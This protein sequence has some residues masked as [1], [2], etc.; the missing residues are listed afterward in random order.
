MPKKGV[1]VP[2]ALLDAVRYRIERKTKTTK[3]A[4]L[5]PSQNKFISQVSH[6]SG[7][8]ILKWLQ[9]GRLHFA[10][11]VLWHSPLPWKM[12]LWRS[13]GEENLQDV[14]GKISQ[15]NISAVCSLYRHGSCH[16]PLFPTPLP[17][18]SGCHHMSPVISG[19]KS[20]LMHGEIGI[21][22]RGTR[23]I[24]HRRLQFM[25]CTCAAENRWCRNFHLL[26]THRPEH[27]VCKSCVAHPVCRVPNPIPIF[28]QHLFSYGLAVALKTLWNLNFHLHFIMLLP[29]LP[30][31]YSYGKAEEPGQKV[32][33]PPFPLR[34]SICFQGTL[35]FSKHF[36]DTLNVLG[37][38]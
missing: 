19:L 20:I 31:H 9:E 37:I 30:C 4:R 35:L 22:L 8:S 26:S 36:P 14:G 13:W 29:F 10:K 3:W 21:G 6:H 5:S 16:Q 38:N 15:Q 32:F 33:E 28:L 7:S 1:S 12:F 18:S 27:R 11:A 25:Q 23:W 34:L 24:R 2:K 17:P